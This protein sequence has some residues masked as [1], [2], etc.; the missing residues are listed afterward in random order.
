MAYLFLGEDHPAKETKLAEIKQ[1]IL[2]PPEAVKFDYE[3]LH[4][5]KLSAED[6]KKSLAS[7]PV[8][9]KE[10]LVVVRECHKL[11]AHNKE[12]I[13][14]FVK[15]PYSPCVL[16]LDS[17]SASDAF[18]QKLE[19]LTKVVRFKA[20]IKL[21]AFDLTKAIERRQ[22][23]EALKILSEL[24]QQGDYPLQIMG[25]LV[26]HWE[27]SRQRLARDEFQKGLRALQEADMNIKRSRLNPDHALELLVVK[28]VG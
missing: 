6:L 7:L 21:N 24:L 25:A 23:A 19:K 1:K 8:I 4:S 20:E 10:R 11:N 27:K 3:I 13:L 12:L 17:D 9:A 5:H 2:T 15:N 18:L 26:W 16:V 28:L 14:E 22:G